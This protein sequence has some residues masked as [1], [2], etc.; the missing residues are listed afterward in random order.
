VIVENDAAGYLS[1]PQ[2]D[3]FNFPHSGVIYNDSTMYSL[4]QE[5]PISAFVGQTV[6]IG[7]GT[8]AGQ[9]Y[10]IVAIAKSDGSHTSDYILALKGATA[11]TTPETVF[12]DV[13]GQS[14]WRAYIGIA[15]TL[16]F[17]TEVTGSHHNRLSYF[18]TVGSDTYRP[19]TD[20]TTTPGVETSLITE[21]S[22]LLT[23]AE[24]WITGSDGT[25][26][27]ANS[28]GWDSTPTKV[29]TPGTDSNIAWAIDAEMPRP[30][31]ANHGVIITNGG[32][33][34]V[35]GIATQYPGSLEVD[36]VA[37]EAL[38]CPDTFTVRW[39]GTTAATGT[40]VL[41][42]TGGALML[43]YDAGGGIFPNLGT[44]RLWFRGQRLVSDA[45]VNLTVRVIYSATDVGSTGVGTVRVQLRKGSGALITQAASA[46]ALI[47]D[48]ARHIITTTLAVPAPHPTEVSASADD[49]HVV[50]ELDVDNTAVL[51]HQVV[52]TTSAS[53]EGVRLLGSFDVVG[54]VRA[55]EFRFS[56]AVP[57][58][59]TVAPAQV[60]LLQNTEYAKL[61]DSEKESG[62]RDF[63]EQ[64]G[65]DVG[66]LT[67]DLI[68]S[69]TTR[70]I[71]IKPAFF[72]SQW[73]KK[74][75]HNTSI[76]GYHPF[77]DPLFYVEHEYVEDP[78]STDFGRMVL[79]GKTGFLGALHPPHGATLKSFT[80]NL[81]FRPCWGYSDSGGGVVADFQVWHS[82]KS[83][84]GI[85]DALATWRAMSNWSTQQGVR[86]R[87]WRYNTLDFDIDM[88]V[89]EWASIGST[90]E[91]GY[92]EEIW[93]DTVSLSG[94]TPPV[95]TA[96]TAGESSEYFVKNNWRLDVD[97]ASSTYN[98]SKLVVDTRHYGY[99]FTVEFWIGTRDVT[100]AGT[101]FRYDL[102]GSS[103][104]YTM[105]GRNVE[106]YTQVG[107]SAA[108]ISAFGRRVAH[109]TLVG[110][111]TYNDTP[112]GPSVS[113]YTPPVPP[114]VKFRGARLGWI[115][116]RP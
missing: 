87:L 108:S 27:P 96:G 111:T 3:V 26:L 16:P 20:K 67:G 85:G 112:T 47:I 115:T 75:V 88:P 90:P 57:G 2:Y 76:E 80:L 62:A 109:T 64:E 68:T 13:S 59:E 24:T 12:Y 23:L 105:K 7:S 99:F 45:P 114:I 60:E 106:F 103:K 113:P 25:G 34:Q 17:G 10:T 11:V 92:A 89:G 38:S 21:T 51:I 30:P 83:G 14:F 36:A 102:A 1:T 66:L 46:T 98:L 97:L 29:I 61:Y 6:T 110:S 100:T 55:A 40:G 49:A 84:L 74:G 15:K 71:W 44:C 4:E 81:S 39:V 48:D 43:A 42:P 94:V 78:P 31:F 77:Y 82:M 70:Q 37:V 54:D 32:I 116:D 79:P 28:K 41:D 72:L 5:F 18:T 107:L 63:G 86:V 8:L 33:L 69:P 52:A 19:K 93:A 22:G 101:D 56:A 104:D 35:G 65:K 95:L 91:F 73:F 53:H 58:Y 50:L 9:V